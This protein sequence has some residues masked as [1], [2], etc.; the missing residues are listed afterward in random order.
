[1]TSKEGLSTS[2]ETLKHELLLKNLRNL[3]NLRIKRF[4]FSVIS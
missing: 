2:Y 3:R 1:M 4:F